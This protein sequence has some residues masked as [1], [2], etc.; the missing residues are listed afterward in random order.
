MEVDGLLGVGAIDD[1]VGQGEGALAGEAPP[2]VAL[3]DGVVDGGEVAVDVAAQDVPEAVAELL[4]AGH[5]SVG[6]L[7][8][9]VGVAVVDEAALKDGFAHRAEG[10]V[11]HAVAEGGPPRPCGAWG[12]RPR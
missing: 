1:Q 4:V 10:V 11:D 5:R 6:A 12:R 2:Q 7:P 9:A 8:L 3:Q